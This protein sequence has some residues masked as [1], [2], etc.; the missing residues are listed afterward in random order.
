MLHAYPK[1]ASINRFK[2]QIKT[3]TAGRQRWRNTGWKKLPEEKLYGE[4]GLVNLIYQ[5]PSIKPKA[6]ILMKAVTGKLYDGF[7]RRTEARL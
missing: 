2:E 4:Y 7:E 5:I 3:R 1:D 6:N